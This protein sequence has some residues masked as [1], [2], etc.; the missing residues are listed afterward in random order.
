MTLLLGLTLACAGVLILVLVVGLML[1][2]LRMRAIDRS[3]ASFR[4]AFFRT[5]DATAGFDR[6]VAPVRERLVAT[7][8]V[9]RGA[10]EALEA[11]E[12]GLRDRFGAGAA[13]AR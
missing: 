13:G 10:V 5:R 6:S 11:A 12:P 7:L 1:A 4:E 3:L 8:D 9:L 2:W